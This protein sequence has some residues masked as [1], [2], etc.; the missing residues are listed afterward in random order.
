M[1]NLSL[2]RTALDAQPRNQ[3]SS[4]NDTIE[5]TVRGSP[6][7]TSLYAWLLVIKGKI[8]PRAD[9]CII[10]R[11][12]KKQWIYKTIP[13][14]VETPPLLKSRPSQPFVRLEWFSSSSLQAFSS[15]SHHVFH[16]I[17]LH[18]SS[19]RG[20]IHSITSSHLYASY[21]LSAYAK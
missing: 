15:V 2:A 21:L 13:L 9:D 18:V 11:H 20:A 10:L 12:P 3:V 1:P 14:A 19:I 4:N 6:S 16:T 7:L 17:R 8:Q 5:L